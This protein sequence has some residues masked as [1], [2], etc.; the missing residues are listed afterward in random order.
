MT[1]DLSY[2]TAREGDSSARIIKGL[3]KKLI[4][5]DNS[6][7]TSYTHENYGRVLWEYSD[8]SSFCD[9]PTGAHCSYFLSGQY[10]AVSMPGHGDLTALISRMA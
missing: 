8:S 5:Y 9:K 3:G 6:L 10:M 2:T 4:Q 1:P 7:Q